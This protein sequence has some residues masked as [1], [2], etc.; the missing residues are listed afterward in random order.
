MMASN[1]LF[2]STPGIAAGRIQSRH[3]AGQKLNLFQSTP[4]IAAGRIGAEFGI[5]APYRG[6][7][8][9]AR[10]CCRANLQGCHCERRHE[11][12][13]STPGIAAGRISRTFPTSTLR[14]RFN[15]RPALLPGESR[16]QST[17]STG[18]MVSIHARH[19]CRANLALGGVFSVCSSVSIHA[20]H[21]CRANR[22]YVGI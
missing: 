6:V 4:G 22:A 1:T 2:Q 11:R 20:R 14:R 17:R 15:P 8:I 3:D 10:H 12:F 16:L 18:R 19:C 7:S 13:Q 21:C 9:H 5:R